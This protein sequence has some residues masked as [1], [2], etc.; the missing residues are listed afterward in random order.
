VN[1]DR[2]RLLDLIG[3]VEEFTFTAS[4]NLAGYA[5]PDCSPALN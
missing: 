2:R 5:D 3:M 4:S 1:R